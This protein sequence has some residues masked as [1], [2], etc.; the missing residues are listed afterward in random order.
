MA[1]LGKTNSI[2]NV[3]F[4]S[5]ILLVS[6][7]LTATVCALCWCVFVSYMLVVCVGHRCWRLWA[8]W[9]YVVM[10]LQSHEMYMAP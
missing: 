2:R 7:T 9:V 8:W 3:K 4:V 6:T 5:C 10:S 1:E